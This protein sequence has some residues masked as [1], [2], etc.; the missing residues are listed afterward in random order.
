MGVVAFL[1]LRDGGMCRR[2]AVDEGTLRAFSEN[3][4]I[5]TDQVGGVFFE[6]AKWAGAMRWHGWTEFAKSG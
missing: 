3:S 4:P 2:I 5:L 6:A 1:F